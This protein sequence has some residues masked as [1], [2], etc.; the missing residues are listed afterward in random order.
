MF[1]IP[2]AAIVLAPVIEIESDCI[3]R[4]SVL[5]YAPHITGNNHR[6]EKHNMI[7]DSLINAPLYESLTPGI[8]AAFEYLANTDFAAMTPGR[9]AID[10]DR[11]YANVQKYETKPR[12]EGVWE[13]HRRYID[14]QYV[15]SGIET[16]GFARMDNLMITQPYDPTRDC[17]FLAGEGDFATLPAGVF[18]VFFPT[19]AHMPG[20]MREHPS[21]ALKVVVKLDADFKGPRE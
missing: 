12:S 6:K 18:A 2:T 17:M 20:L 4:I 14:I 3:H 19:D 10:G 16:V 9:H 8:Q 13:A 11:M 7:I 15:V 21:T 5:Q 1:L